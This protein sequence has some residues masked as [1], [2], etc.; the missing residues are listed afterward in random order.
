MLH[1]FDRQHRVDEA[2][3]LLARHLALGNPPGPIIVALAHALL[4][5]DAGFHSYQIFEA[6]VRQ[7]HE[8]VDLEPK[9]H[10]MIA[11][12]PTLQLTSRLTAAPSARA[13]EPQCEEEH[14]R[15]DRGVDDEA[16]DTG[17]EMNPKTM[18]KPV[19]YERAY[20]ANR[21]VP[22][23]TKTRCPIQLSPPA[24]RQ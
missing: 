12:A 16:N 6:G 3:Q 18:Q 21:R 17:A 7:F 22:D 13:G 23:E 8:W 11:V 20:D 19:A 2:A 5:E 4:R 1:A 24:V 15:S 10:I 14:N 9:R